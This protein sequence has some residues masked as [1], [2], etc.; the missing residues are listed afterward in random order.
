MKS[1]NRVAGKKQATSGD[2][3]ASSLA[4][5]RSDPAAVLRPLQRA[6]GNRGVNRLLRSGVLEPGVSPDVESYLARR[7]AGQP[8]AVST[9]A[10]LERRF[11]HDFGDVRVHAD[12]EAGAS[13]NALDARAYTVGSDIFF[14]PSQYAPGTIEGRR[15]LA[16][17]LTHVV[18]QRGTA[19]PGASRISR[20]AS[21]TCTTGTHGAPADPTA[22]I[23]AAEL[24]A[25]VAMVGA[26]AD[27]SLLKLDI[28]LPGLGAGG[29]YTMPTTQRLTDYQNSWGLPTRV[30]GTTK[31]K[32]RLGGGTFS[33]QAE[34]LY[35]EIDG[36]QTRFTRLSNRVLGAFN[37]RCIGGPTTIGSCTAHCTGRAATSCF[38]TNLIMLCP[39]FWT[40]SLNDQAF[41]LI[42]E[43][44]HRV[45]G[46]DHAR[47]F[48]HADC[49]AAYTAAAAG[50][51]SGT[52]PVCVP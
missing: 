6:L 35:N 39:R 34:A 26:D 2:R 24:I 27:L 19:S 30:S 50:Q 37:Y 25:G 52:S 47:N 11:G 20:S 8:L 40:F 38:N 15:L 13:A 10:D 51:A 21:V 43:A 5:R 31:F 17:E 28:I 23:D 46:I 36:L 12:H 33:S 18:Q 22:T 1:L 4:S 42:H 45:F 29:G 48:R 9:R 16:H 3:Q 41:L 44:S 49:Y 14:G 32:D 7:P